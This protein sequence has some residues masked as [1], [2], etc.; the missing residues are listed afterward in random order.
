MTKDKNQLW[1][2]F[3]FY[4]K[5]N[6]EKAKYHDLESLKSQRERK[7]F[8][9]DFFI[10]VADDLELSFDDSQ[11]F[12]RVDYTLFK[13][14]N[15]HNW[16]VPQIFIESENS[17]ESSYEEAIKLC[18]LNAPLKVLILYGLND[19]LQRELDGNE[20]HWD[21]IFKDFITESRLIGLF[22]LII[23]TRDSS[24]RLVFHYVL[25]GEDGR[26]IEKGKLSFAQIS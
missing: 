8:F 5:S 10:K 11:E 1:K 7:Y 14:G 17:W 2:D 18:S 16:E 15:A 13:K 25:Y 26:T 9:K 3:I 20:T 4:F 19:E 23:Y 12:L 22:A 6:I 24:D 21:Y